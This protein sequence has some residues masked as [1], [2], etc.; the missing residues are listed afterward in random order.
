MNDNEIWKE[1]HDNDRYLISNK[2]RCKS[3]INNIFLKPNY[4]NGY[5]RYR[6]YY[7]N[8]KEPVPWLA[9]RL[10]AIAFIDNPNN[11]PIINHIN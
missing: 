5:I 9:H 6:L 4:N 3:K 11:Y 8:K 10:V 7:K 1:V 2:G